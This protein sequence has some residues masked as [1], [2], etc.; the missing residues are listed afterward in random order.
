MAP[1]PPQH[2]KVSLDTKQ[3]WDPSDREPLSTQI[4]WNYEPEPAD[5]SCPVPRLQ[6]EWELGFEGIHSESSAIEYFD[7]G[8]MAS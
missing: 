3:H 1:E 8:S 7:M 4:T 5:Q 6:W 2:S